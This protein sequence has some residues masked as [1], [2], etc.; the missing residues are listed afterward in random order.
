MKYCQLIWDGENLEL[1][2]GWQP[3]SDQMQGSNLDRLVE[4]S[5]RSC[6]DSCG[7]GRDSEAYHQHI[8]EVNHLSVLEHANFTIKFNDDRVVSTKHFSDTLYSLLNRPGIY[9][10]PIYDQFFDIT[11]N[12]RS[13]VEWNQRPVYSADACNIGQILQSE[14]LKLAP[15]VCKPYN[16]KPVNHT[17]SVFPKIAT[18]NT[19]EIFCSIFFTNVSRGMT[20]ELVRHRIGAVSQRSTR[21]VDESE[22]DWCWHPLFRQFYDYRQD[23]DESSLEEF[24]KNACKLYNYYVD[25]LQQYLIA[26]NVDKFTARKQ[27]RGAARGILGNALATELLYTTSLKNWQ[28][29]IKMRASEAADA[30]I[31]LAFNDVFEILKGRWPQHFVNWQTAPCKD[32]MG[33]VVSVKHI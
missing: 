4:I 11:V 19:N 32:G 26:Q 33:F 25:Q 17:L 28:H 2:Q 15:L 18:N 10:A 5:G 22:S 7:T 30:E 29:M 9:V 14:A 12:L 21:Y 23:P 3:R 27:S 1:P 24:R 8:A 20:H 13:V 31:R 6:Y 16:F